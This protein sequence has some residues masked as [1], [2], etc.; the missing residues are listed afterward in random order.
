MSS[1]RQPSSFLPM[2]FQA[3]SWPGN[4]M[5]IAMG[6]Y[7]ENSVSFA[8]RRWRVQRVDFKKAK[9]L[10]L[11]RLALETERRTDIILPILMPDLS[12]V[13]FAT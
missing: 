8:T 3:T 11:T 1:E 13:S 6:N 5:F 4:T 9:G 2:P 7:I 12:I 10:P